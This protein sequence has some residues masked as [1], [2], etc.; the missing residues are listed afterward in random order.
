MYSF[1]V[2][3]L[4]LTGVTMMLNSK[5]RNDFMRVA[6]K[7]ALG[8]LIP[9]ALMSGSALAGAE[10]PVPQAPLTA[11]SIFVGEVRA[12]IQQDTASAAFDVVN[13]AEGQAQMVEL[14][15]KN[16]DK[17]A[18]KYPFLGDFI[19]DLKEQNAQRV[20]EGNT[21]ADISTAHYTV[22]GKE[23][24]FVAIESPSHCTQTGCLTNVY[25]KD[26][27][28][29]KFAES[30]GSMLSGIAYLSQYE[31][32]A[33]FYVCTPDNGREQYSLN[34]Q[35]ELVQSTATVPKQVPKCDF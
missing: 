26:K 21:P 24:V 27:D 33:S 12:D 4:L 22:G 1:G 15:V 11:Q 16:I 31:G 29:Q 18:E 35:N 2:V 25:V 34:T 28:G 9:A 17:V 19:K 13:I 30:F 20:S 5:F 8:V 7:A 10:Q 23:F 3:L 32:K 14:T 6:R